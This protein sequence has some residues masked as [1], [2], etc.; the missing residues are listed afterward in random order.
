MYLLSA[1]CTSDSV[2]G[3]VGSM[4]GTALA[5]MLFLLALFYMSA[6]FFRKP[7]YEAF[8]SLELY[9]LGI[10][11]VL[12]A[13]IFTSACFSEQLS[14]SMTASLFGPGKDAF[15]VGGEYLSYVSN[16]VALQA[17][18]KLQGVLLLSQ[19]AGSITMRF[20]ASVWGV[21][22]PAFPSFIVLERLM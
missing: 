13:T 18:K 4:V 15:D 1:M 5:T 19:W 14:T 9:Q 20:G 17:I 12:F 10:S 3:L 6:Q 2:V 8:V 16:E 22:M 7:E 21:S 11:A